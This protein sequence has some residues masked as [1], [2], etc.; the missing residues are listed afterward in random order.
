MNPLDYDP[1]NP[2][3]LS[4][5]QGL[6]QLLAVECSSLPPEC[7]A[8]SFLYVERELAVTIIFK[9][10]KRENFDPFIAYLA[11]NYFDRFVSTKRIPRIMSSEVYDMELLVISCLT[12]AWK[13]RSR[14]FTNPKFL[15]EQLQPRNI[16]TEDQ[17]MRM[18]LCILK[19]LD[20]NLCVVTAFSFIPYL[21]RKFN[22]FN[23]FRRRTINEIIIQ[24][25]KDIAVTKFSPSV[26]A[27]ASLLAASK[28]LY[29]HEFPDYMD[30]VLCRTSFREGDQILT[31]MKSLIKMCDELKLF[32]GKSDDKATA[33]RDERSEQDAAQDDKDKQFGFQL[34]WQLSK[35][36]EED[37]VMFR[38]LRTED[39]NNVTML[40]QMLAF[41][42]WRIQRET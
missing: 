22:L 6:E 31:C 28:Y 40:M 13:M 10:W 17:Y 3:P 23:R 32:A 20:W 42:T 18:E 19:G 36:L 12:L 25:Q 24:S 14:S 1:H 35:K 38:S 4:E 37:H 33:D 7:Y 8:G 27:S 5:K 34:K 9:Y 41:V 16:V 21:E 29:P 39:F 11:L 15:V 2:I 30:R 26:I